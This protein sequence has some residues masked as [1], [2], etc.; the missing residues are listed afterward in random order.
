MGRRMTSPLHNCWKGIHWRCS[1]G[2]EHRHRYYD[3]GIRVCEE[4]SDYDTFADFALAHG[5]Q[6][7]LTIDRIDNDSGYRP[8]N[9][10]FV[11]PKENAN[12]R[13]RE[14]FKAARKMACRVHGNGRARR[15]RCERVT[16]EVLV[17]S[18]IKEALLTLKCGRTFL[19]Y[20]LNG[21]CS[22]GHTLREWR[23]IKLV[24]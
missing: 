2:Y 21:T 16:G 4:W 19:S 12:N 3:R 18:S 14:H 7:G 1:V 9:V 8:G 23:S 10:R 22:F 13:D 24:S 17:F 6:E 11:T 20:V 5:W 15:I